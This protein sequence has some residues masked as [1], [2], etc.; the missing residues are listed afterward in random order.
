MSLD[1]AYI[2][3]TDITVSFGAPISPTTSAPPDTVSRQRW[4][5]IKKDLYLH[6]AEQ[7]AWLYAATLAAEELTADDLVVT[8]VRVNEQRPV[9][10][11]GPQWEHRPAG[12]WIRRSKY[13]EDRQTVTDI[14]VLF[15]TDAVDPRP[16]WTLMPQPLELG[17]EVQLEI[18][19]ARLSL[20][21]GQPK[22][23]PDDPRP[24]TPLRVRENGKFRIVQIS[25][26]HMVTGMGVC[27]DA[28]DAEGNFL[29][30]SIADPLTVD[31]MGKVL[32]TEQPD[33]VILTGDQVH[34][35]ILD[36]Q[37]AIFK[38]VAPLIERSI[39][40]AA[41]F[42]N[43]D[44]EGTYALSRTIRPDGAASESSFQLLQG[45]PSRCRRGGKLPPSDLFSH[46]ADSINNIVLS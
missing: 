22:G 10:E 41:V 23:Q 28:I 19:V 32:D 3:V 37:S 46:V 24:S 13:G 26:T 8:Q 1:D 29:P 18:P 27:K 4:H 42:G 15:G 20:R 5:R 25:D 36:S 35:D 16:Y 6:S 45:R 12:I 33:L 44:A 21:R 30:P 31:F 40:F 43:H 9:N 7:T 34:H 17:T 14:D 11:P 38:V 2:V 39:P